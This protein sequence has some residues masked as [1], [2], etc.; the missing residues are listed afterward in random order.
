MSVSEGASVLHGGDVVLVFDSCWHLQLDQLLLELLSDAEARASFGVASPDGDEIVL[1]A[2]ADVDADDVRLLEGLSYDGE[3]EGVPE[4]GQGSRRSQRLGDANVPAAALREALPH[5]QNVSPED[6]VVGVLGEI[7]RRCEVRVQAP[8]LFDV[9]ELAE[10]LEVLLVIDLLLVVVVVVV[11]RCFLLL[12]SF[13]SFLVVV[14]LVAALFFGV[15]LVLLVLLLLRR[16]LVVP[17]RPL[18]F[19]CRG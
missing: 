16:L 11:V 2:D 17:Y 15:L 19:E 12:L 18:G 6:V 14:V 13:V 9:G 5:G 4:S 10:S 7:R 3:H 8:E 1:T